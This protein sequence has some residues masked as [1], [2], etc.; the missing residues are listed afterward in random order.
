MPDYQRRTLDE[1]LNLAQERGELTDEARFALDAELAE[2]KVTTADIHSYARATLAQKRAEERRNQRS[3]RFYETRYQQF[4]GKK[5]R[6]I[7]PRNRVEE[8][9]TTLW[10]VLGLPIIPL[11]SYRI[12]R[13][14]RRWWTFCPPTQLRILESRPR[15]WE[16]ILL[17]W[18]KIGLCLLFLAVF[19]RFKYRY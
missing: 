4:F 1:L 15:D 7:D 17:T 6:Y 16:Q 14:F 18:V 10:F 11:R 2:R 12:R 13:T 5:N 19:L 9:D 3:R 8:F